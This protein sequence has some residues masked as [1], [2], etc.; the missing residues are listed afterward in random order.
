MPGTVSMS[1]L[2]HEKVKWN[3]L[4]PRTTFSTS[5]HTHPLA[6]LPQKNLFLHPLIGSRYTFLSYTKED[7]L[8]IST[9]APLLATDPV[10]GGE[11]CGDR[12]LEVEIVIL[13][14][15]T[16]FSS[17][18]TSTSNVY[19]TEALVCFSSWILQM[20]VDI[21][22]K[23]A[24]ATFCCLS[25]LSGVVRGAT[26]SSTFLNISIKHLFKTTTQQREN[27]FFWYFLRLGSEHI[28]EG[29]CTGTGMCSEVI[30]NK[31][32]EKGTRNRCREVKK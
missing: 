20:C 1:G 2:P 25:G 17:Y 29:R 8:H 22:M 13:E 6:S 12:G 31:R 26:Y 14:T 28:A 4:L 5:F 16:I 19:P 24:Y 21:C 30:Q 9:Q 11:S 23:S 15:S 18:P 3:H 27:I 7:T 10:L 32:W